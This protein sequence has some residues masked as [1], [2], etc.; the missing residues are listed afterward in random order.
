MYLFHSRPTISN[1]KSHEKTIAYQYQMNFENLR[2]RILTLFIKHI[3]LFN[4]FH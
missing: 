1:K 2:A 4:H 3:V